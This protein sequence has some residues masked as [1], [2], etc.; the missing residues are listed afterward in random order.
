MGADGLSKL[1]SARVAVFGV[2]GVGGYVVEALARVGIGSLDI[3]DHDTVSESNINRQLCATYS[4]VGKYKV[5]VFAAR[6]ADINPG[7]NVRTYKVFFSPETARE[8]F[9]LILW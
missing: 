2:G 9:R 7:A 5:D 6:I 8:G 1:S 4:T 3:V